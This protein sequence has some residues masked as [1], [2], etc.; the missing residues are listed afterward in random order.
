MKD[1]HP[2]MTKFY[3]MK[4]KNDFLLKVYLQYQLPL[5]LKHSLQE[6]HFS[7]QVQDETEQHSKI[8][9]E[10]DRLNM[11]THAINITTWKLR[12]KGLNSMAA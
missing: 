5:R 2:I 4:N 1:F 10:T 7:L 11:I 8:L 12:P 3:C 6:Q 9:S